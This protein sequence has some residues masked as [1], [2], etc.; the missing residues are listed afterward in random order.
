MKKILNGKMYNTETANCLAEYWNGRSSRDFRHLSESL[1]RKKNGEFFLYGEGGPLT[2]YKEP[3]GDM[4]GDGNA[5][6]PL[7]ADSAREWAEK[8]MSTD[9]YIAVFGEPEE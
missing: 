5:I 1:Y 6:T 9:E 2:K 7:E 3:Y 8:Y 4:W